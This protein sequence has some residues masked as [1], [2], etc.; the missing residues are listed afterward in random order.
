MKKI[1]FFTKNLK[2]GGMEKALITLLDNIDYR[3]YEVTLV[4][5]KKEGELCN[6][7]NKN[8]RIIDYRLATNRNVFIRKCINFT[9]KLIFKCKNRN[10]FDCAINYAT[11]SIWGSH[12]A[13]SSSKNT[14]L[15][16]HSDY[17]NV[18]KGNET[19]IN[20]FFYN[21]RM[22]EFSKVV[23]VSKNARDNIIKVI[24]TISEKSILLGNLVDY[25]KILQQSEEYIP[26]I[27]NKTINLLFL[28]RL[29]EE[30]KNLSKLID[31]VNNSQYNDKFNIYIIGTGPEEE[32]YKNE[33]ESSNIIF[34][35]EL[36]NPYPYLKKCDYLILTSR[37]EG[38]PVVYN[39]AMIL[40]T[41][42]I[43]TIPVEDEQIKYDSD[44][45]IIL[46]K[47]LSSFDEIIKKAIEQRISIEETKLDF[48]A[49][50]NEKMRRFY[51]M[52]NA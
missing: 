51:E 28:G 25:K 2:I 14:I 26:E 48:D 31:K 42:I 40:G 17:Y 16:I 1:V 22:Q 43:T 45:V 12:M 7:V 27:D 34:L 44:N 29:E 20:E 46:D 5:E 19:E 32:R 41:N 24:P 50:N 3:Q 18:F 11:Y 52:I 30:S 4:L 9:K 37:F 15:F 6:C 36:E 33:A 13:L 8:V 21:I 23:F 49:I 35:G 10:K 38:F 47:D 39:E